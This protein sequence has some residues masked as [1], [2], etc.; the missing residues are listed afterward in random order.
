MHAL[1]DHIHEAE[2]PIPTFAQLCLHPHKAH[3]HTHTHTLLI[4]PCQ[5]YC[6][7]YLLRHCQVPR[8]LSLE[9]SVL[10]VLRNFVPDERLIAVFL[11]HYP[12]FHEP[13]SPR[14]CLIRTY[15]CVFT[16]LLLS[17]SVVLRSHFIFWALVLAVKGVCPLI[18]KE[19]LPPTLCGS[20]RPDFKH[21]AR[22]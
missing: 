10:T 1:Y 11:Y 15:K 17:G 3:T 21:G 2:L 14:S 9:L 16:A 19:L 4:D 13:V 6:W 12:I 18:L 20:L 7:Y 8:L 22:I 5:H